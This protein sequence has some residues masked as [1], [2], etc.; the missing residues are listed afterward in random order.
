MISK[1]EVRAPHEKIKTHVKDVLKK[2]PQLLPA[3]KDGKKVSIMHV[4]SIVLD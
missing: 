1:V 4:F 2:L 3:I